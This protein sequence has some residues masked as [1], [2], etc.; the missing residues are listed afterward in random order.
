MEGI[1]SGGFTGFF[2]GTA[3]G[4]AGLVIKPVTGVLDATS[5]TAEGI[6]NQATK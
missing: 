4:I 3:Q 6:K 1:K 2:K 5:K